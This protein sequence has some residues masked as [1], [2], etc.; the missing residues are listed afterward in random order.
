MPPSEIVTHSARLY[1]RPD[2]IVVVNPGDAGEQT[3]ADAKEN[4]RAVAS[5]GGGE[6]VPL[7][8]DGLTPMAADA[9]KYYLSAESHRHVLAAAIVA[10]NAFSRVIANLF[11][12]IQRQPVPMKLFGGE[13]EALD[14]LRRMKTAQAKGRQR[15]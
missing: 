2:G 10:G 1:R 3:L 5:L 14:W 8:I 4:I 15:A 9:Q 11:I 12:P 13:E 6:R 7:F